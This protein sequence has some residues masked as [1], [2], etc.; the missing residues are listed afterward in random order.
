[1]KYKQQVSDNLETADQLI[2]TILRGL[3]DR[4]ITADDTVNKLRQVRDLLK[5]AQHK[6]SI[7]YDNR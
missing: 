7:E 6:V 5:D 1:M 3:R 4:T 2:Y